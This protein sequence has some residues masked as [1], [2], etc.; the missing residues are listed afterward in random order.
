MASR[1][2]CQ[3]H[4]A[5]WCQEDTVC[6]GLGPAA[7]AQCTAPGPGQLTTQ[8]TQFLSIVQ[9]GRVLGTELVS[10]MVIMS[11]HSTPIAYSA[12]MY[13]GSQKIEVSVFPTPSAALVWVSERIK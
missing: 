13:L 1:V 2:Q 8:H 3:C 10:V 5:A 7:A 6:S 4:A 12:D 11:C 9:T